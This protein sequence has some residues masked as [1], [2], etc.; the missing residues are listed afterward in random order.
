MTVWT[1]SCGAIWPPISTA[2]A[3]SSTNDNID[4]YYKDN[5]AY[6]DVIF[7]DKD[8]SNQTHKAVHEIENIVGD[9]GW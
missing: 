7:T 1:W 3:N 2:R 4:D 9:K 8:S 5:T 6:M